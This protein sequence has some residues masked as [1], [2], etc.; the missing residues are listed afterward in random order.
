MD[1]IRRVIAAIDA[2]LKRHQP[3]LQTIRELEV[4]IASSLALDDVSIVLGDTAVIAPAGALVIALR[5]DGSTV[6]RVFATAPSGADRLSATGVLSEL[7][8][9]LALALAW[10]ARDD[11]RERLTRIARTDALTGISNRLAFDERFESAWRRC[12]ED[13]APLGIALIDVDFFKSYND[14]YG[15]TLGDRCL[16][17][18]A[19]LLAQWSRK[20]HAFVARY[21]GEEFGAVFENVGP[22]EAALALNGLLA[23]LER[24]P[25]THAGST[26]GRISPSTG[27]AIAVPSAGGAGSDL[28]EEADRAMYRAKLLG[29]NRV[30]V[31]ERATAGPIVS[32]SA[33]PPQTRF[34]ATPAIGR[35]ADLTRAIAGLRQTRL[36]TL[37]G[38]SGIGKS[39]LAQEI[40]AAS[41]ALF[42]GG[43]VYLDFALFAE[44]ADPVAALGG[45][46]DVVVGDANVQESVRT[47]LHERSALLIFDNVHAD[48]FKRR[49]AALCGELIASCPDVSI[50]ATAPVGLGCAE[51]RVIVV[52][53]LGDAATIALLRELIGVE[54]NAGTIGVGRD[55]AG[56]R[57]IGRPRR[58]DRA[59]R[60]PGRC[61]PC[62]RATA[63]ARRS[64]PRARRPR[65]VVRTLDRRSV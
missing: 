44:D 49:V 57:R 51:E 25:I 46:L 33:T 27:L 28:R 18:I 23:A 11:D 1:P 43:V 37:V 52:P 50:V 36:L 12:R 17:D 10:R 61:G 59:V 39:R 41:Q 60:A 3:L 30:C 64:T 40:G 6:A 2:A 65:V 31:G 9:P 19:T 45:T 35:E 5:L 38:P 53:P 15:H 63:R 22:A 29:R 13:A 16:V 32:R 26:L 48:G 62:W 8:T 42:A 21:G 20:E 14:T 55:R 34:H 47:A 54:N 24:R 58:D 4:S 7:A 56:A